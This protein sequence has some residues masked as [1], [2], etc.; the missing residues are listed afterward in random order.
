V[1]PVSLTNP[2]GQ[3]IFGIVGPGDIGPLD[4]GTALA[5]IHESRP[6][7]APGGPFDVGV[8]EDDHR[9][10]AFEFEDPVWEALT[11]TIRQPGMRGA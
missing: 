11:A 5:A 4:R 2:S 7:R 9:V 6:D 10:L 1:G 8:L 3:S